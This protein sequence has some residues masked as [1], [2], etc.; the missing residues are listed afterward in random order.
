MGKLR[1]RDHMRPVKLF[2][3]GSSTLDGAVNPS[4][5][6]Q[7]ISDSRGCDL[8]ETILQVTCDSS[9]LSSR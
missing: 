1:L 6:I 3:R 8:I 5:I 2:L 7:F 4:L 9:P